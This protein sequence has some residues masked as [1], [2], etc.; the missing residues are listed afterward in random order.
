MSF[1]YKLQSFE[2]A[3]VKEA[4]VNAVSSNSTFLFKINQWKVGSGLWSSYLTS[5]TDSELQQLHECGEGKVQ[6]R[7]HSTIIRVME[8]SINIV[9]E[10]N[11]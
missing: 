1:K 5:L 2:V 10:L 9:M 7:S 3:Q 8:K 6:I 11:L 4:I